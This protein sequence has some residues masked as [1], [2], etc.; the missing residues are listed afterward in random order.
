M[1]IEKESDALNREYR[2]LANIAERLTKKY[3]G[4][5]D[6][7]WIRLNQI[8]NRQ[9]QIIKELEECTGINIPQPTKED[10]LK[11]FKRKQEEE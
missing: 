1:K 3:T 4:D 2:Q 7:L 5:D 10:T 11:E 8:H 9:G 6:L